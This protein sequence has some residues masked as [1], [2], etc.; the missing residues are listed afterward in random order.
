LWNECQVKHQSIQLKA[1]ISE[2]GANICC[3]A[4]VKVGGKDQADKDA[5]EDLAFD[6]L[7]LLT[8]AFA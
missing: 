5:E 2:E 4:N 3:D 1:I 6:P 8:A 7:N